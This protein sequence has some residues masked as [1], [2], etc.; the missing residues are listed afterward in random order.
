MKREEFREDLLRWV[1][2][3]MELKDRAEDISAHEVLT[4]AYYLRGDIES[5]LREGLRRGR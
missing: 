2:R 3:V 5:I 1:D 4:E